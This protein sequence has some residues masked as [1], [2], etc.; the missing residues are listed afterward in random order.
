M[1]TNIYSKPGTNITTDENVMSATGT[2]TLFWLVLQNVHVMT[3]HT[4]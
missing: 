2:A 4:L 1:Y 3:D